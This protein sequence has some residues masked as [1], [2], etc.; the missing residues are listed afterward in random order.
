MKALS[1][2]ININL[3]Q[4]LDAINS[5]SGEDVQITSAV[6]T[7]DTPS[8]EREKIKRIPP[9]I[10]V[11]TPES[12]YNILTSKA[13]RAMMSGVETVIVDEVHALAQNKRGA[14]LLLT[15][16]RLEALAFRRPQRIAVSATQRPIERMQRYI[17][18][19]D[20]SVVVD[21]GHKRM[22]DL[23]I[24]LPDSPLSCLLYT[25]PSPRD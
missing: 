3:Q 7:G 4:P 17:L 6:W 23:S 9:H 8:Y 2:D 24:Q 5:S 16:M 21:K 22:M 20:F 15:L 12:L 14:H 25:S 18:H 13:G 10:L 19:P 11:T 1:N